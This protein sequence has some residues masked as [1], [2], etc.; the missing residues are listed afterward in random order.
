VDGVIFLDA[1]L[2]GVAAMTSTLTCSK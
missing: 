2:R 1:P